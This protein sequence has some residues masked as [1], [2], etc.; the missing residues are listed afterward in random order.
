MNGSKPSEIYKNKKT[1]KMIRHKV[2]NI[3]N[4]KDCLRYK[5]LKNILNYQFTIS[6]ANWSWITFRVWKM[7]LWNG[8]SKCNSNKSLLTLAS[9][10]INRR[11]LRTS[12]VMMRSW[13]SESSF[14]FAVDFPNCRASRFILECSCLIF[15]IVV[16]TKPTEKVTIS[17]QKKVKPLVSFLIC[18]LSANRK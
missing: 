6:S 10:F 9:S 16:S 11:F 15:S 8:L 18:P 1:S 3:R 13:T 14:F 4:C 2:Q 12:N 7:F 5:I 17:L